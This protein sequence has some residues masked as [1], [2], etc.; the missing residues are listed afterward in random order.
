[1][2]PTSSR[3]GE[4]IL[5]GSIDPASVDEDALNDWWTNEHLPERLG[6]PGFQLAR[7]YRAFEPKQGQNEYLALY[8]VSNVQDLAS[9]EYMHALNHPTERTV[10]FMPCLASM[11]RFACSSMYQQQTPYSVAGT[12][13]NSD[14]YL[15]MVVCRLE[16]EA[17]RFGLDVHRVTEH[18]SHN[19]HPDIW[20]V[21]V[22]SVSPSITAQGSTSKSY[23]GVGFNTPPDNAATSLDRPNTL[24]LLF[25]LHSTTA[26]TSLPTTTWFASLESKLEESNVRISYKNTYSLIATLAKDA[27]NAEA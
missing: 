7:R 8:Q 3:G 26:P 15:F 5:W 23:D 17:T 22:S 18:L 6:L 19:E 20:R 16:E 24:I 12:R 2:Y 11:N 10:Q 21:R 1:M 27:I 9:P 25:D 4:L 14:D 13:H